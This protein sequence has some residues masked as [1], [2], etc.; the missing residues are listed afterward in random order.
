MARTFYAD[1]LRSWDWDW[2]KQEAISNAVDEALELAADG[3]VFDEDGYP[4]CEVDDY[5]FPEALRGI[6]RIGSVFS[7]MPS[8]KYYM[9][10]ACSNV[11]LREAERDERYMAALERAADKFGGWIE[12]GEGDPCDLFFGLPWDAVKDEVLAA[13]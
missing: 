11:T 7:V 3:C 1:A 12:S 4:Y 5:A 13:I 8:G 10:W 2:L 6:A 9:P